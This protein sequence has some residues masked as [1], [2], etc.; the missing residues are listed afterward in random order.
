VRLYDDEPSDASRKGKNGWIA[1][2]P[3]TNGL[4]ASSGV[5]FK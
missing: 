5:R 1:L 3:L 4:Y 2:I